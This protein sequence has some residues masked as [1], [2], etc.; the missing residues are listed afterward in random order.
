MDIRRFQRDPADGYI[1]RLVREKGSHTR[2][3]LGEATGWARSTVTRRVDALLESGLLT[4][5]GG[6]P[7]TGGRPPARFRFNEGAGSLVVVD[8]GITHSRFALVDL[9]GNPLI[10][11]EDLSIDLTVGPEDT[12]PVI[13]E[14]LARQ[15]SASPTPPLAIG[16][17]LPAPIDAATGRPTDP[18]ILS[19]WDDF[20]LVAAITA[21]TAT[22]TFV[23]KDVNLM[24][25]GEH[26]RCWPDARS[27]VFV[28]VGTG[29]GSGIVLGR[30]LYRGADGAAGDIGHIQ[31]DGFGDRLCQCGRNGCLEAVAGGAALAAQVSALGRRATNAREVA[32]L[33][34]A[35]D[36]EVKA[37][38]RGAGVHIGA[39]LAGVVSIV[40]PD[41]IVLGGDLGV[42]PLILA[43][44]RAEVHDRPLALATRHLTVEPSQLGSDAGTFG[45]A[46]LVVDRL[47]PS[48][49]R[50]G[51]I[52]PVPAA[53]QTQSR[54]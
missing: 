29:I 26:R 17:G 16:V 9:L 39:V 1:L 3:S 52:P 46:E 30:R 19:A 38:L 49:Q 24:A 27:L 25:L 45:A 54:R 11:P 41:V 44:V 37:I 48:M 33:S 34:G 15:M 31:M 47:W 40:N 2:A 28:K 6:A 10:P 4:S 50:G 7:S 21:K 42:E 23:D 51:S 14:S 43:S 18:P 53:P 35:G 32:A 36:P 22:V 20:P 8:L 12:L 13:L 5:F